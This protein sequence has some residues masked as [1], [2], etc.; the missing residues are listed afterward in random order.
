MVAI[1]TFRQIAL[2]F[3]GTVEQPHFDKTS[4]RVDKKIFATLDIQNKR[5]CIMLS[6]IDQSVFSAYDKS[7]Y[8]AVPNKWGKR[9]APFVELAKVRKI[10][11]RDSLEQAYNK[12]TSKKRAVPQTAA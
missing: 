8:Y 11:L 12:I 10:M 6:E 9:G 2:S 1:K 4:F 3:P 5:A 7:V